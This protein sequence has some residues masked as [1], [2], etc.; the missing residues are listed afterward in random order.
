[1]LQWVVKNTSGRQIK[2]T[3]WVEQFVGQSVRTHGCAPGIPV[4]VYLCQLGGNGRAGSK[5]AH[6]LEYSAC[7]RM[8]WAE[9][10]T[11]RLAYANRSRCLRYVT[12]GL[13]FSNRG[14]PG[15]AAAVQIS[16]SQQDEN[17]VNKISVVSFLGTFFFCVL[18]CVVGKRFYQG[19]SAILIE[20]M[21]KIA[22]IGQESQ[23]DACWCKYCTWVQ[24]LATVYYL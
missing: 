1:M 17:K 16:Y 13:P 2:E 15:S 14:L 5:H 3:K 18:Q 10:K 9:F 7:S 19:N 6:T 23:D 12:M 20:P 11:W 24:S 4:L 22:A 21:R 8:Q